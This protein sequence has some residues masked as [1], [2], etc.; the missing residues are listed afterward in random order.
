[1]KSLDAL[2][3]LVTK[4]QEQLNSN[5][6]GLEDLQKNLSEQIDGKISE[7]AKSLEPSEE[8]VSSQ[9]QEIEKQLS[10]VLNSIVPEEQVREEKIEEV[11]SEDTPDVFSVYKQVKSR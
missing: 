3:E 8:V 2:T 1:M 6:S 7:F 9:K 4:Q 11:K 5:M 10:V